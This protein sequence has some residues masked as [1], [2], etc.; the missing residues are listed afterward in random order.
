MRKSSLL[1]YPGKSRVA[2]TETN[3]R[4]SEVKRKTARS[5]EGR[6]EHCKKFRNVATNNLL[7][8]AT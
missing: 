1:L 7:L 8:L 4:L 5:I 6:Q 3:L 2:N